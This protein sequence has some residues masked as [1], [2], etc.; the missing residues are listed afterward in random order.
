[1]RT[2]R[3]FIKIISSLI[4]AWSGKKL[5][6]SPLLAITKGGNMFTIRKSLARGHANHGWL[7]SFHT[8]SFANYYDP[9]QMGFRDLRV[10]NE[11][12]IARGTGFGTHP[13]KDME[14]ITYVVKGALE[15]KD[16]M[17]NTAI[18]RPGEVQKMSAGTGVRHSEFNPSEEEDIHLFQIWILPET[19]GGTPSYGQKSFEAELSSKKMVLVVSKDEREGSIGIKQDVDM[20]ISRL[21][22]GESVDFKLRPKR[23]AWIQLVK[24]KLKIGEHEISAG[25]AISTNGNGEGGESSDTQKLKFQAMEDSEFILFDLI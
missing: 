1:M 25:D 5:L 17:G 13:H 2:R 9:Q 10:I 15:H 8:F 20:Y 19:A 12:Y 14:I 6:T 18:I 24:G 23:G 11:D 16:S 4:I 3:D 22:S 21:K 7:E